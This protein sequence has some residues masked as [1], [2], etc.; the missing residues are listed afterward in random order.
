MLVAVLAFALFAGNRLRE[1]A[2]AHGRRSKTSSYNPFIFNNENVRSA[3]ERDKW[4]I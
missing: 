3:H 2:K 4:S 1:I